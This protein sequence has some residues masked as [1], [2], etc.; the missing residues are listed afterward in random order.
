MEAA[1]NTSLVS[2]PTAP[3]VELRTLLTVLVAAVV[4]PLTV[5][6]T[7]PSSGSKG[8]L[9]FALAVGALLPVVEEVAPGVVVCDG[10]N[11]LFETTVTLVP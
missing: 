5:E 9:V 6:T 10:I 7:P 8:V 2:P 4:V 11:G 1:P 3:V